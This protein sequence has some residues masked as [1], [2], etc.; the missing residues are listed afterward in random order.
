M[1]TLKLQALLFDTEGSKSLADE[2][3]LP[4]AGGADLAEITRTATACGTML[5]QRMI[6]QGAREMIER[7]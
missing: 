1:T 2:I 3:A 4:L 6:V 5:G 7:A